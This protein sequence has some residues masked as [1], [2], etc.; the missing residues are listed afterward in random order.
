M[1]GHGVQASHRITMVGLLLAAILATAP[2]APT[3]SHMLPAQ[4]ALARSEGRRVATVRQ[5]QVTA[6]AMVRAARALAQSHHTSAT[7]CT[8]AHVTDIWGNVKVLNICV[9]K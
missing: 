2:T 8:Y 1:V 4:A 6:Y 3:H 5:E 9:P 7:Q